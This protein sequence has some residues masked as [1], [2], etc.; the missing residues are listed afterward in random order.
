[1]RIRRML[2]AASLAGVSAA[3]LAV[4]GLTAPAAMADTTLTATYPADGTAHIAATDSDLSLG[5]GSLTAV[6]DLTTLQ[7]TSGTLSLPAATGT[8]TELG[9]VPVTATVAFQQVGQ[10]TGT[11]NNDTG[12][13]TAT[14]QVN[15]QITDLKVAGVDVGVGSGC[16]T[17]QPA[18][19]TVNSGTPFNILTGG[20]VTG[21][22][23]VPTFRN[24]G[25]LGVYTPIINAVI[26]GPGNT[27]S[28]TLG[29]ATIS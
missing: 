17:T 8:F 2:V 5:P 20:P 3:A 24:C 21:S 22:F 18:S 12:A 19:I 10:V 1:M 29:Q 15:L 6:A 26:P 14:T 11:V 4:T 27:I 16:Q 7:I 13:V 25:L 28:L 23:A 9:F